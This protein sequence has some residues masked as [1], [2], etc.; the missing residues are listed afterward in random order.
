MILIGEKGCCH[1]ARMITSCI[2]LNHTWLVVKLKENL[3]DVVLGFV[4]M[5]I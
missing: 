1:C 5:G 4:K 3:M 2:P